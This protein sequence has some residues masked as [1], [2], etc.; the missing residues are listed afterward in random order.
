MRNEQNLLYIASSSNVTG[1]GAADYDMHRSEKDG[2]TRHRSLEVLI[3]DDGKFY[4]SE[5]V[6]PGD[7]ICWIGE[8]SYW[9]DSHE[10]VF[11]DTFT[12][13]AY[14]LD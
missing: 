13:L 4:L 9:E 10:N 2:G 1:N 12:N 7:R 5:P 11:F 14:S 6:M 8:I 3:T